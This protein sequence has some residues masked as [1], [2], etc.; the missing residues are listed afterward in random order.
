M[1]PRLAAC[2]GCARGPTGVEVC[3]SE[4]VTST[5]VAHAPDGRST[6][7]CAQFERQPADH[8]RERVVNLLG[9]VAK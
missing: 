8:G 9:T 1:G 7:S 6:P 2:A 4:P 5:A 3:G